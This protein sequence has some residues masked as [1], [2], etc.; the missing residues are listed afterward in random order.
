MVNPTA[1]ASAR[2]PSGASPIAS[3]IINA[4][5]QGRADTLRE[6]ESGLRQQ[7][8]QQSI[9]LGDIA[10]QEK[11]QG[12]ERSNLADLYAA[13]VVNSWQG[14]NQQGYQTNLAKLSQID[15]AKAAEINS[16]LGTLSKDG[17]VSGAMNLFGAMNSD[18]PAAQDKL[19]KNA[20]DSL[21]VGPQ[22]PLYQGIADIIEMPPGEERDNA[23]IRE[24]EDARKMGLYPE[25][26]M[27]AGKG[28]TPEEIAKTEAE[29][30]NLDARTAKI[31]TDLKNDGDK[32]ELSADKKFDYEQKLS[33]KYYARTKNYQDVKTSYDTLLTSAKADSGPGDLALITSFMKML[34]PGSVVRE[35]E[36]ANAQDTAGLYNRVKNMVTKWKSGERLGA[37]DR[38]RFVSLSRQY[39]E[40]ADQREQTVRNQIGQTVQNYGL[41]AENIFPEKAQT[42]KA[43][44]TRPKVYQ[45]MAEA[46]T[47]SANLPAGTRIQVGNEI[48]EV[49]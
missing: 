20:L 31:L 42:G 5:S 41:N 45:S 6:Q 14:K 28:K 23:I 30:R 37:E 47:A 2:L 29:T 19:L 9:T 35:T 38:E 49:E 40:A 10:S 46:E 43:E 13:D 17:A 39:M 33:D 12:Q 7:Q 32:G 24:V 3:N 36:F 15:K 44:S 1:F 8:M 34:D 18:N 48:F 16:F 26:G 4:I 22:H 21:G 11:Q 27:G 25:M